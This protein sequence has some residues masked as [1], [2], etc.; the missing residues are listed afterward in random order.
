V[1]VHAGFDRRNPSVARPGGAGM[2][3]LTWN[4]QASRV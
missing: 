4:L 1:A 3:V 2:T